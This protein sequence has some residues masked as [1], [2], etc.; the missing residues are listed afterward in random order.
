MW[1]D[2][3]TYWGDPGYQLEPGDPGYVPPNPS[4]PIP[5]KTKKPKSMP[6]QPFL[7]RTDAA[8]QP[9]LN[10]FVDALQSAAKGYAAKYNVPAATITQLDNGRQWVNW[11]SLNLGK[12]RDS[13]LQATAFKDQLFSGIG[14]MAAAPV[15]PVFTAVPGVANFAGVFTLAS[16]V[17]A[18]IKAL[19]NYAV[20]D[21]QD[22]GLEGAAM[23]AP[24]PGVVAP[25]LSRSRPA[26]GGFN[27]IVWKKLGYSALKIMVDRGD[28][29][30][31]VFLAIDSVPNYIDTVKPAP[32]ASATYTYHA[33]YMMGDQEFGQWSQPLEMTLRG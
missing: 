7:P 2:P 9:W 14:T 21:G 10:T 11:I 17:G 3:N 19:P 15:P 25:D 4:A 22:M 31:E 12:T 26:S 28:G 23:P 20:S 8:K 13:S 24:A 33:I 18:A 6:K 30:G 29:K 5:T 32:G 1:D 27:E 16:S